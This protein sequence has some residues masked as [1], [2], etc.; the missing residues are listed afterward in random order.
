VGQDSD[1]EGH[2]WA[3]ASLR[4][5]QRTERIARRLPGTVPKEQEVGDRAGRTGADGLTPPDHVRLSSE[6]EDLDRL[7]GYARGRDRDG[8]DD[9]HQ[10]E[11][12]HPT[13]PAP[14]ST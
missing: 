6:Q 5:V 9:Q 2:S 11:T 12:F 1:P 8:Q 7:L 14:G 4:V 3:Y 13:P 10:H